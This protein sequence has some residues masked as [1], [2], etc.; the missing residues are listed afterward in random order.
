MVLSQADSDNEPNRME[1]VIVA[2]QFLYADTV[3]ALK[4][5]TPILDVPQSLSLMSAAD[6]RARGFNTIRFV[7]RVSLRQHHW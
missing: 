7:I 2:G 3:N 6:I 4:S 1:E 5:P